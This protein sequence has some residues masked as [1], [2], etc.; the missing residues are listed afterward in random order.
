VFAAVVASGSYDSC[1]GLDFAEIDA[2]IREGE[3]Q[4][5]LANSLA[6]S[7]T[8]AQ[9]Q[10][11]A[12]A[13]DKAAVKTFQDA[14]AN[15]ARKRLTDVVVRGGM[16]TPDNLIIGTNEHLA[17][18]GLIGFSVQ[19]SPGKTVD[20]LAKAG[21]WKNGQIAVTTIGALLAVGVAVVPSPGKGYHAT[22]V[23]PTGMSLDPA[24]AATISAV[25]T[26]TVFT[27]VPN[28]HRVK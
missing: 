6:N 8:H 18:P 1:P 14:L 25:F 13:R 3:V 12:D 27:V 7:I 2:E 9:Q 11:A 10:A 15:E 4:Q 16:A 21:E 23:S 20:E 28:P 17:Q 5:A 26:T 22:A 19:Y 24:V